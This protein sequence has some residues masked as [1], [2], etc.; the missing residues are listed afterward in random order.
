MSGVCLFVCLSVCLSVSNFTQKLLK[1]L[2]EDCIC[3]QWRTEFSLEVIHFR[4]L[5]RKFLED[6]SA[7]QL[8]DRAFSHNLTQMPVSGKSDR[9]FLKQFF[10][11]DVTSDKLVPVK[12]WNSAGSGVQI[13]ILTMDTSGCGPD[14][15]WP[16]CALSAHVLLCNIYSV[17]NTV[18][19]WLWMLRP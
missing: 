7:L 13:G 3:G 17:G 16:R 14:S 4:I 6:S 5:I 18:S 11:T 8:K 15:P 2:P 10:T 12:F 1:I 9:I 19:E